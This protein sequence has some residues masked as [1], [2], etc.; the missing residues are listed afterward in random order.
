MTK[1]ELIDHISQLE[2]ERVAFAD[3]HI[4]DEDGGC[5][6]LLGQVAHKLHPDKSF[7]GI[8]TVSE[9]LEMPEWLVKSIAMSF[10]TRVQE[11]IGPD[12]FWR[13]LTIPMDLAKELGL[14]AVAGRWKDD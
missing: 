1:E 9:A 10:D 5:Y 3:W 7:S 11:T 12:K 2:G 4:Y 14:Q 6:C 8:K 13:E